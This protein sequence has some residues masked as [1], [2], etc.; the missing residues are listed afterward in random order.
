MPQIIIKKATLAL[1]QEQA[2]ALLDFAEK[3]LKGGE[4]FA[5][6]PFPKNFTERE[7]EAL[8]K[9]TKKFIREIEEARDRPRKRFLFDGS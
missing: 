7:A 8:K 1:G 9:S 5:I 3:V 4:T 6:I 2:E